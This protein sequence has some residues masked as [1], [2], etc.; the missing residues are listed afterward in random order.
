MAHKASS[1]PAASASQ[2]YEPITMTHEPATHEKGTTLISATVAPATSCQP[3]SFAQV[4]SASQVLVTAAI[5]A[6]ALVAWLVCIHANPRIFD[7]F[8]GEKIGGHFSQ[9]EAKAIDI[10]TGAILAPLF[11][12]SL[13]Y[14]WFA[15]AR[16]SVVN[17][18]Q[19]RA[20]PLRT[21]VTASGT[22]GGNYD[23]FQL[24]DLLQGKT[25]RLF[26]LGLLTLLSAVS[27]SALSNI[28]AYEAFSENVP[29]HASTLRVQRDL[30]IDGA[31]LGPA[32]LLYPSSSL[33][34]LDL[35]DFSDSQNAQ[36]AKE[37]VSLLTGLSYENA[38][39]KLTNGT[40][41][42]INAT[43]QSLDS[44]PLTVVEIDNVPAYR[45]SVDCA[46]DLPTSISVLQPLSLI[47]TQIELMLNTTSISNNTL[48]QANYP[49][50]PEDIQTYDGDGY[51]YAGF[52]LGSLEAYLGHLQRFNMTND[53]SPSIY[54]DVGFRA[55]NMTGAALGFTGTQSTMSVSGIRCMLYRERG[56]LN[57]TRASSNSSSTSTWTISSTHFDNDQ[58]KSSIPSMLAHFQW[59]NLN[60]HAPGAVIPGLG[61][62][63]SNSMTGLHAATTA[64]DTFTDFALNFLYA[65]G[66]A[67]RILY[68]VAAT[69]TNSS[70]NLHDYYVDVPGFITQ[71][72][73]RITYVPSILLL[74]L[75]C[76][77]AASIVTAAMAAYVRNSDSA[78]A[79]R[80]VDVVRLLVDSVS[81]LQD[82]RDEWARIAQ[83]GNGDLDTWAVGYKVRYSRVDDDGGTVQIVLDKHEG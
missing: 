1:L 5:P 7:T 23:L 69:S 50:V 41:V 48:F 39:S 61:P 73:Y 40:Y 70:K 53:T 4:W 30:A 34:S 35:Y 54:G 33:I 72:Q 20:I 28:I 8:A 55:F 36:V 66:E 65:S 26:L 45:L 56:L 67:Q 18:Q 42:G 15:N 59:S 25:W 63:L 71:Q 62:A 52:S 22:S 49:G 38:A 31:F 75:L 79:H 2:P 24:R 82:S 83:K 3:R 60:F 27:R 44:L 81:G 46:P 14:I 9:A 43:S 19:R 29:S 32:G 16:V 21:L 51:S 6:V 13:N 78:R 74:G 12:A 37:M 80:R 57:Y 58:E 11:M 77:L 17:E 47:N 76:L 68:E 64:N 10:I